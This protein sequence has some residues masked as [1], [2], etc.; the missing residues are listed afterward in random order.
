[1]TQKRKIGN[2]IANILKYVILRVENREKV[3]WFEFNFW[4]DGVCAGMYGKP[5]RHGALRWSG[6]L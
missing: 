6:M 4:G 5:Q 1:M 3:P 2:V